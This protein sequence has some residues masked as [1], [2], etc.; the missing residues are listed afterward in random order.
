MSEIVFLLYY[1]E[2]PVLTILNF[3][4]FRVTFY[5]LEDLGICAFWFLG[6]IKSY[7]KEKI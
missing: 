6:N 3:Q 2:F 1:S 4:L 7:E 5:V